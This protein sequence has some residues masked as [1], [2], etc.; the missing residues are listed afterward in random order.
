M[1]SI[2]P[3]D[4]LRRMAIASASA[5]SDTR[6]NGH[7]SRPESP[8]FDSPDKRRRVE[9]TGAG[10]YAGPYQAHPPS[11][12]GS[13]PYVNG[14]VP[15]GVIV[16]PYQP[17]P[18]HTDRGSPF[19]D[20]LPSSRIDTKPYGIDN[21]GQPLVKGSGCGPAQGEERQ[22]LIATYDP[23]HPGVQHD[24]RYYSAAPQRPPEPRHGFV[25]AQVAPIQYVPLPA[26]VR[27]HHVRPTYVRL[28]AQE[29]HRPG[30]QQAQPQP[31]IVY[32]E[33]PRQ[34]TPMHGA[35]A[36]VQQ[37]PRPA[38]NGY[39]QQQPPATVPLAAPS[40]Y[41]PPANGQPHYYYPR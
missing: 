12:I 9:Q 26:P 4:D 28:P 5:K 30:Y 40:G 19:A 23:R 39:K 14:D 11:P 25:D 29:C 17:S 8:A 3:P 27:D 16:V 38:P 22:P 21:L 1:A 15:P 2:E 31:R 10:A 13:G 7:R 20:A 6:S 34:Y 35:P 33:A 32:V 41:A 18:P 37:L 24:E 36:A